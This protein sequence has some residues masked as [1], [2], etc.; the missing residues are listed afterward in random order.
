MGN[1]KFLNSQISKV[2]AQ[3]NQLDDTTIFTL[4]DKKILLPKYNEQ[5]LFLEKRKER[6]INSITVYGSVKINGN[7]NKKSL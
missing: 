1:I 7:S 3:I 2:K 4:E 6:A 5:L